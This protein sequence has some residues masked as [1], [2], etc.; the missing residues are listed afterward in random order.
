MLL[1]GTKTL[2][3]AELSERIEFYGASL[4][5][6]AD[7]DY[8][9]ISLYVLK[10]DL[11]ELFRI[12]KDIIFYPVF[13]EEELKKKKSILTTSIIKME[14]E[15]SYVAM[16]TLRMKIFKD[17]PYGRPVK[18]T[19]ESIERIRRTD[20][21]D[22]HKNFYN[23]DGSVLVIVGDINQKEVEELIEDFKKWKGPDRQDKKGRER[24]TGHE[25]WSMPV[26]INRDLTQANI[27][28]GIRGISRSDP[29]YYALSV[30]N[31]IL[32][33]GGFGSRLVQ[34]I[35]DEMGLAYDVS[36]YFTVNE[37]PGLFVIELQTKN[38]SAMTALRVIKEEIERIIKEPVSDE[39]LEDAKAYLTGSLPRRID[40]TRKIAEFLT[41]AEF[42]GLGEDYI[43]RYPEYIR[44][45][46]KDDIIRVAK[47]LLSREGLFVIV[48]KESEIRDE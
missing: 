19:T 27:V 10:K 45:V 29:D 44:Q 28:Y 13:P 18:G 3:A 20:L 11:P 38:A 35:R 37:E 30:M 48:G 8:T 7:Y 6:S 23:P 47:R 41:M 22:F 21:I 34:K 14:E 32:G 25:R 36:S 31:Y 43:S 5:A 40:T 15:P 24:E 16:K 17:H 2:R 42:Y 9:I 46:T 4:S 26:I 1:E 39:E 12:F 33:G